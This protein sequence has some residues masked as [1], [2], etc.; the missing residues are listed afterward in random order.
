MRNGIRT[1]CKSKAIIGMQAL[2]FPIRL[3][4]KIKSNSSLFS[5]F[6]A[7]RFFRETKSTTNEEN[8]KT[9]DRTFA[10]N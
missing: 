9:P 7:E 4:R 3:K 6:A 1:F 8:N 5:G 10:D 2:V